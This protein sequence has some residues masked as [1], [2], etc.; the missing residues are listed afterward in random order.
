MWVRVPFQSFKVQI[1]RLFR[2]RSFSHS[3]K[4]NEIVTNITNTESYSAFKYIILIFFWLVKDCSE[5]FQW[6]WL[7]QSEVIKIVT[8]FYLGLSYLWVSIQ[9][10]FSRLFKSNVSQWSWFS[11]SFTLLTLLSHVY[12]LKTGFFRGPWRYWSKTVT[13]HRPSSNQFPFFWLRARW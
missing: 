8:R 4:W 5:I 6:L 11:I 9:T 3:S 7:P 1:S 13:K 10:Q 12:K 2:A